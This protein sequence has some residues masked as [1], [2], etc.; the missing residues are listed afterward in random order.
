MKTI[1]TILLVFLGFGATAQFTPDTLVNGKIPV[2]IY[3][4]PDASFPFE[5]QIFN[6]RAVI[7]TIN[8]ARGLSMYAGKS[9]KVDSLSTTTAV[10]DSLCLL[11]VKE[12]EEKVF[13]TEQSLEVALLSYEAEKLKNSN[14]LTLMGTKDELI[15]VQKKEIRRQKLMKWGFAIGAGAVTILA[16]TR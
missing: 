8:Q 10:A 12:L 16:I 13:T 4:E 6:R 11:K 7:M 9:D 2:T 3:V 1:I 5:T 15:K 14:N